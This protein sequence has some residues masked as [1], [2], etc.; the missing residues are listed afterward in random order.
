MSMLPTT[1]RKERPTAERRERRYMTVAQTAEPKDAPIA[2]RRERRGCTTVGLTVEPKDQPTAALR[3][4]PV[5]MTAEPTA[6][7]ERC[8]ARWGG[9]VARLPPR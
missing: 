9:R 1:G 3:E 8:F 5:C 2:A 6:E 4:H 7:P